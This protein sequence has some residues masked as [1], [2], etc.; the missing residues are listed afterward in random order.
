MMNRSSYLYSPIYFSPFHLGEYVLECDSAR[1][2]VSHGVSK[3]TQ[4]FTAIFNTF[5]LMTL[6]NE[7]NARKIHGQRNVFAGVFRNWIFIVIWI[8]TMVLQIIIVE[9]GGYAFSTQ[10]LDLNQW[11]W[12]LFFGIGELVWGQVNQF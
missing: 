10:G 2:L 1:E 12:C 9:F 3:P 7:L 8:S 5:V 4:H 11:M 6:F